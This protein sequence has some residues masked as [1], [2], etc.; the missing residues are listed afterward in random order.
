MEGGKNLPSTVDLKQHGDF[1]LP[2]SSNGEIGNRP[3]ETSVRRQHSAMPAFSLVLN[4]A[5]KAM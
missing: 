1:I 4:K 3:I 5:K 2:K